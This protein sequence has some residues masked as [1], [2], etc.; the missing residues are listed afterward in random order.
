MLNLKFKRLHESAILP[1]YA[2]DQSACFDFYTCLYPFKSV[3]FID[4]TNTEEFEINELKLQYDYITINPMDRFLIPTGISADIPEDHVIKIYSRSGVSF[5]NGLILS[6]GVGIIDADYVN[7][8]LISV[9]NI[10]HDTILISSGERVAQGELC[11]VL[12]PSIMETFDDLEKKGN[13][14]GGF[15]STGTGQLKSV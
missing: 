9:T 7:E 3:Y 4:Q 14:E 15:G 6:N 12:R 1:T 10:G 5:K 13:R 2:T 8:I 11:K